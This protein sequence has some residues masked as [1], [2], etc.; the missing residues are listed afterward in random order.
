M[1]FK[2]VAGLALILMIMLNPRLV[3]SQGVQK[4]D[5]LSN[6][7][8]E[9]VLSNDEFNQFGLPNLPDDFDLIDPDA[10]FQDDLFQSQLF[11]LGDQDG[12]TIVGPLVSPSPSQSP[13]STRPSVSTPTGPLSAVLAALAAGSSLLTLFLFRRKSD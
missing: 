1:K 4:T 10:E 11:D 12:T 9:Q 5:L 3:R 8:Q 13:L 2:E 6:V 7:D